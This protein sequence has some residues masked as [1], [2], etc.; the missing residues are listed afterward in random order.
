MK[1][2]DRDRLLSSTLLA[3]LV[4][5]VVGVVLFF[6]APWSTPEPP[7]YREPLRVVFD[8][9]EP[10]PQRES[11]PQREREPQPSEPTEPEPPEP[12]PAPTPEP[13]PEPTPTPEAAEEPTPA[14]SRERTSAPAAPA[15]PWDI[16]ETADQATPAP[17]PPTE[18]SIDRDALA[19][20]IPTGPNA[21]FLAQQEAA[22]R[23]AFAELSRELDS[24]ERLQQ[25][26]LAERAAYP[27]AEAN[28]SET[29]SALERRLDQALQD[30]KNRRDDEA[31]IGVTDAESGEQ[32]APGAQGPRTSGGRGLV[33]GSPRPDF[34]SV[35]WREGLPG[36]V[37]ITVRFWVNR[38]GSV[39]RYETVPGDLTIL[40]SSG[41]RSAIDRTVSGWRFESSSSAGAEELGRAVYVIER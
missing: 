13:D 18:R 24:V 30:L 5:L 7:E 6:T 11:P 19:E 29:I 4:H 12:P 37:L 41:L 10:E 32:S 25:E 23:A 22:R 33:A 26:L 16:P 27:A 31:V 15:E 17:S 9:P 28:R 8:A 35:R 2:R 34:S 1:Q 38:A 20:N 39:V 40:A 14:P 36:E 3:L 21:E